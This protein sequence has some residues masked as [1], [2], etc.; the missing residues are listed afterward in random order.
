MLDDELIRV[1]ADA[2]RTLAEATQPGATSSLRL[3]T[4]GTIAKTGTPALRILVMRKAWSDTRTLELHTDVRS[5]KWDELKV[6]KTVCVLGYD[7]AMRIQ[8]RFE[9]E[10]KIFPP[11]TSENELAWASLSDWTKN[12]YAG[13][14]PGDPLDGTEPCAESSELP[15]TTVGRPRFG[16]IQ[17]KVK[18]L[19]WV[20]LARGNNRRAVF[21][22]AVDGKVETAAWVEP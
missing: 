4:L 9:G 16:V 22:Y 19:D 6:S 15:D 14:P 12:T 18:S 2:W 21:E 5:R 8:L 10:A 11:E 7:D 13:G 3:L 1:N 17:I 20:L